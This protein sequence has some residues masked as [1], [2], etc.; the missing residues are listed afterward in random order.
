MRKTDKDRQRAKRFKLKV[1]NF[2][3]IVIKRLMNNTNKPF[4]KLEEIFDIVHEVHLKK[5]RIRETLNLLTDEDHRTN[6]IY[7]YFLVKLR[8]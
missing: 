2:E 1:T 5:S 6:N 8:I 3:G 7:I 4:V